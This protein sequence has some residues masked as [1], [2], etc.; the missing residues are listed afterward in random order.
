MVSYSDFFEE[1]PNPQKREAVL[2]LFDE[3]YHRFNDPGAEAGQGVVEVVSN[4]NHTIPF[5]F[6]VFPPKYHIRIGTKDDLQEVVK[7]F[8]GFRFIINR[9]TNSREE[10]VQNRKIDN[11][12]KLTLKYFFNKDVREEVYRTELDFFQNCGHFHL[13]GP[14]PQDQVQNFIGKLVFHIFHPDRDFNNTERE[15]DQ[16]HHFLCHCDTT[17]DSS[18]RHCLQ[19]C[20]NQEA[21]LMELQAYH[22]YLSP[23]VE[24]GEDRKDMPVVFL[25]ACGSS[26]IM[27]QS[28]SF[29]KFFLEK[30]RNPSFVGTEANVPQFFAPE[31]SKCF[32]KYLLAGK[33]LGNALQLAKWEMLSFTNPLGMLYTLYGN[34][35]LSVKNPVDL[36]HIKDR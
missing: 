17:P 28:M 20:Q 34:P 18:K 13:K 8:F 22:R 25:N 36:E 27:P 19:F 5:E 35:D 26:V 9:I 12:S 3:F 32:Y 2:K 29:P 33:S 4:L 14:W 7:R 30:N 1:D 6:F 23:P 31:F 15:L 16:V 24:R 11:S 10:R 21:S